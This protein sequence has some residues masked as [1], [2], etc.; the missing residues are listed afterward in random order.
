MLEN[1]YEGLQKM[2]KA[3]KLKIIRSIRMIQ[4][5]WRFKYREKIKIA[6][7]KIGSAYKQ[8]KHKVMEKGEEVKILK[9]RMQIHKLKRWLKLLIKKIR[10]SKNPVRLLDNRTYM[11]RLPSIVKI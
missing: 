11:S 5:F 4:K 8:Y 3:K 7:N 6:C 9:M 1:Q 2:K 10:M